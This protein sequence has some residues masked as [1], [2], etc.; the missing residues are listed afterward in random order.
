[1]LVTTV[2]PAPEFLIDSILLSSLELFHSSS[3]LRRDV[4]QTTI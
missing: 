4:N 3:G 2:K 1:M